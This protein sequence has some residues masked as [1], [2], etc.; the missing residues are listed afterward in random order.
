MKT[1]GVLLPKLTN[2]WKICILPDVLGK[3]YT[4]N[5]FMA[6]SLPRELPERDCVCY[7]RKST[8][9]KCVDCCNPNCPIVSFHLS[10]LKIESVPKTWYYPHC[11]ILPQY[12]RSKKATKI[13]SH[14]PYPVMSLDC[15]CICQSNGTILGQRFTKA[16]HTFIILSIMGVAASC[17]P[18]GPE[19]R[20]SIGR[21]LLKMLYFL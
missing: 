9:K 12:K 11:R 7:C 2:F 6:N 10:C 21:F 8:D 16:E 20:K 1:T 3:W 17:D 5:Q 13:S 15:I 18:L 14:A 19:I 4:R